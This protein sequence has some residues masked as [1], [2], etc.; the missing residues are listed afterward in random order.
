MSWY[1][2]SSPWTEA[3]VDPATRRIVFAAIRPI[4]RPSGETAG[5]A[6]FLLPVRILT[7]SRFMQTHL[8]QKT[9][10]FLT[11]ACRETDLLTDQI[12]II[13]RND[14]SDL[15]HRSWRAQIDEKRLISSD[16]AEYKKMVADFH[17][18]ADNIRRMPYQGEDSLWV[19]GQL[20]QWSY[21][22]LITPYEEILKPSQELQRFLQDMTQSV[23]KLTRFIALGA[24]CLVLILVI[25]FSRTVTRPL[26]TLTEGAKRL[27]EGDFSTRVHIRTGDEFEE[28]GKVFNEVVPRLKE[29]TE[30]NHSLKL[31]REIQQ[32]LLPKDPPSAAGLDIWG[33]SLYCDKTGGD[34][35]DFLPSPTGNGSPLQIIVG[36]VSGHGIPSALLMATARAFI[37]IRAFIPGTPAELVADVNRHLSRDVEDSGQFMTLFY[38]VFHTDRNLMS[39]VC[40]GH[41]PALVYNTR[42]DAFRDL[43]GKHLPLAVFETSR[44]RESEI[45]YESGWIILIGTDGIWETRNPRGEAFGK[46]RVRAVLREHQE[47]PAHG[48]ITALESALITF[49]GVEEPEDDVTMVVIKT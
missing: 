41:D 27:A 2:P 29:N 15:R 30:L 21:I 28:M 46:N 20:D 1:R 44:Y 33:K 22:V 37:R 14:Y 26:N 40:A 11:D 24:I 7:E 5:V 18:G 45:E 32:N 23:L 25:L 42:T 16:A 47:K 12:R 48:I 4:R 39:W 10:S 31:A 49:R 35:Y 38:M 34:Y 13:A 3:F 36:D 9:R 43:G 6:A 19:Y 17:E 8:P